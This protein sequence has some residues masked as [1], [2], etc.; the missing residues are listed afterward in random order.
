MSRDITSAVKD[1]AEAT[2]NRPVYLVKLEYDSADVLVNSTNRSII[3]DGDTYLGV[4][5]FGQISAADEDSELR[6]QGIEAAL[7]GVD[8]AN[9]SIALDEDYQGRDAT[10]W[11]GFL[12]SS[13]EIIADPFII[14]KGRMDTQKI[15]VGAVAQIILSIENR[16]VDWDRPRVT[17][18]NN[19]GQ[20]ATYTDDAGL[21]FVEQTTEKVIFWGIERR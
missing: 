8:G 5:N 18:Y 6:A 3:F 7:S 16:F 13:Y 15:S 20:H 14:F 9:I 10:I 4:G 17:R 19:E 2:S 12:D 11:L 1:E 21:E